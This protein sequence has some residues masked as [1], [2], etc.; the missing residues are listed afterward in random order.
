[1]ADFSIYIKRIVMARSKRIYINESQLASLVKYFLTESNGT[2]NIVSVAT[3]VYG[4]DE[5]GN[6]CVLAGRRAATA[7][8]G[9]NRLNPPMGLIEYGEEPCDAAIRE[10]QEETGISLD[11]GKLV[12]C[13]T[14]TYK[15]NNEIVAGKNYCIFLENI[16]NYNIGNGDGEN[17]RFEWVKLSYINDADWAFGTGNTAKKIAKQFFH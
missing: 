9:A 8:S 13:G 5:N 10:I 2:P 12:D 16:Y 6:P 1:M 3:Y 4:Y 14:E 7:Y 15:F 17:E 11:K